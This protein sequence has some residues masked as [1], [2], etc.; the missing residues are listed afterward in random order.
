MKS[1]NIKIKVDDTYVSG[2]VSAP[3]VKQMSGL[4]EDG[5]MHKVFTM[6]C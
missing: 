6:A 4:A 5:L 3:G 1:E 2:V